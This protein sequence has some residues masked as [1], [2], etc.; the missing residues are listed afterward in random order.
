MFRISM[1]KQLLGV[2]VVALALGASAA[3][4]ATVKVA[5]AANFLAPLNALVTAYKAAG[6]SYSSS[7]FTVTS[8]ATGDLASAISSAVTSGGSTPYDLFFAADD[9]TP[10]SLASTLSSY[11]VVQTPYFY[12]QGKLVL[13]SKYGPDVST[14]GYAGFPSPAGYAYANGQVAIANPGT[15]PYGT[16]AQQVMARVTGITYPGGSYDAKFSQY[17]TITATYNAVNASTGTTSYPN[18]GFVAKSLLCDASTGAIR[19]PLTGSYFEYTPSSVDGGAP[20]DRLLQNAVAIRGRSGASDAAVDDFSAYVQT[21]AAKT[22]IQS[23]C[24]LTTAS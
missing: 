13:W 2:S 8:G 4:A 20:H 1:G 10:A 9:T 14:A 5:V 16:A 7:T 19:S 12:A 17:S 24:Y 21:A 11:G 22:I 18:L 6:R 23:Y 3:Q 15:A